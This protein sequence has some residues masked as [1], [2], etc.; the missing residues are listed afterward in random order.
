MS[1][2]G[3]AD[4][5][6]ARGP[7]YKTEITVDNVKTRALLDHGTQVSTVCREL[8][9]K[10]Q[11]THGLTKDQYQARNQKLDRQPIGANGAELG[12]VALVRLTVELAKLYR[13]HVLP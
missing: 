12:A 9:P 6:P 2:G 3:E 7:T 8:H 11:E 1:A 10:M 5:V 4:E 13:F